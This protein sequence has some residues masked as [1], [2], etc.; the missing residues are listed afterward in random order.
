VQER[1]KKKHTKKPNNKRCKGITASHKQTSSQ[2]VSKQQPPW[3]SNP[4]TLSSAS[5][6]ERYVK[7]V[8]SLWNSCKLLELVDFN[9]HDLA[10]DMECI[11]WR[12]KVNAWSFC[13][14]SNSIRLLNRSRS[15]ICDKSICSLLV[16]RWQ[17]EKKNPL[18]QII[19]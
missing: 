13:T 10:V 6:R 3:K 7:C 16:T 12:S 11:S 8:A 9:Q 1:G 18:R 17:S 4:S 19:L 15:Y 5:G 2:T 14:N